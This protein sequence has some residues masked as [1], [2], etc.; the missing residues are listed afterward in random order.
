MI[1]NEDSK[2]CLILRRISD[3]ESCN[4]IVD[5]SCQSLRPR[6]AAADSPSKNLTSVLALSSNSE[7]EKKSLLFTA[8]GTTSF[9]GASDLN[10]ECVRSLHRKTATQGNVINLN[11]NASLL[12]EEEIKFR[13]I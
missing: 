8:L 3:F 2:T 12:L 10:P 11:T 1:P 4:S 9:P 5:P 13:G 7:K 6:Q